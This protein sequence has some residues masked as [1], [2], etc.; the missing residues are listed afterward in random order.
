MRRL[1]LLI[2]LLPL[3]GCG[4]TADE[5]LKA[6]P[7]TRSSATSYTTRL[8][9]SDPEKQAVAISQAVYPA[10]REE[11]SAGAI[12]LVPQD[13]A[14]AFTA[15]HRITHMPITAPLF[16]LTK[17][18]QIGEETKKEMKRIRPDGVTQ[19]GKVQ[20]YIIGLV[21]DRV[22]QTVERVLKYKVRRFKTTDPIALAELLDR[23]SAAVKSDH[24]DEVVISAL[25]HPDGMAHGIG[26][27]GWN[28]HMGKGFAWVYT[29][30]IPEATK[31]ILKRRYGKNGS[32]I[33]VTG[34]PEV[35]SNKVVVE[36][37]RYGLVR[38]IFG[39][40][41]YQS[42]TVNAGY[43]D[44]G[45]NF[46]WWWG[47]MPRSFDWG[48]SQAGHNFIIASS[49][50]LMGAIPSALLGHMGKHGPILLVSPDAVPQPVTDY[51]EM[52]RPFLSGPTQTIINHA[53]IIGNETAV[54]WDVQKQVHRLLAPTGG[55]AVSSA[56]AQDRRM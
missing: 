28:A 45:R 3:S 23:W 12:I 49:E 2:V 47:W 22:V 29:H 11:N 42:N 8:A 33:Y 13:P 32:Y 15:M 46:G 21:E 38:R 24:P 50:D 27:M 7:M 31:T 17:N 56:T 26:A 19:D 48:I 6:P 1:I 51:L 30:S 5:P 35:I 4:S 53:W 20:V 25:D 52:V 54:S 9:A 34:G 37:S 36:L 43:K 44:F 55:A 40:S 39:D 16:Y 14:L 18:G 10:T 41:V